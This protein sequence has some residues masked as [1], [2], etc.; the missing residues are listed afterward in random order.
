M[1]PDPL[2]EPLPC[3]EMTVYT[4]GYCLYSGS[5]RIVEE[6]RWS[7]MTNNRQAAPP[8]NGNLPTT[9]TRVRGLRDKV[10]HGA[11]LRCVRL[12]L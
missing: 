9:G 4:N 6:R 2:S 11:H 1:A 8:R 5:H 3:Q 10:H 7:L 12:H